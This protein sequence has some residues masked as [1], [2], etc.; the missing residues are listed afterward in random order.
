ME[1]RCSGQ[2]FSRAS[3]ETSPTRAGA[4]PPTGRARDPRPLPAAGCD[5]I[6]APPPGSLGRVVTS[7]SSPAGRR[8]GPRILPGKTPA[9][10]KK[11][12]GCSPTQDLACDGAHPSP[13]GGGRGTA[14]SS[15]WAERGGGRGGASAEPRPHGPAPSCGSPNAGSHKQLFINRQVRN[16]GN[17]GF[18]HMTHARGAALGDCIPAARRGPEAQQG[19]ECHHAEALGGHLVDSVSAAGSL[20]RAKGICC[21]EGRNRRVLPA[22]GR[23]QEALPLSVQAPPSSLWASTSDPTRGPLTVQGP[24]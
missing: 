20:R 8:R 10:G 4:C 5:V 11:P 16:F 22:F 23:H 18:G 6:T 2:G 15:R 21:T 19:T 17:L 9:P 13:R 24:L 12:V 1:P 3:A 14:A 7:L